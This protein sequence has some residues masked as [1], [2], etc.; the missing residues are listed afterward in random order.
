MGLNYEE[1]VRLMEE[2]G[3][4]PYRA[5]QVMDWLYR[6]GVADL[7]AMPA[8]PQNLRQALKDEGYEVGLPREKARREGAD[9]TKKFLFAMVDGETI[10][11]VYIPEGPRR[12]VCVSTQVG[13]GMGCAFCATGQGGLVRNLT[14]GEI[15]GQ[16]LAVRR[17]VGL[18]ITN[19]VAMG[20]GEPL[21]N[22]EAT[23]KAFRLMGVEHGMGIAAR[24]LTISTCGLPP[25]IL[26]LAADGRQWQLTVSLHAVRDELRDRLMPINRR[27]PLAALR[28]ACLEYFLRVG[29]RITFAYVVIPGVNDGERDAAGLVD[30]CRGMKVHLNLIPWNPV[31]GVAFRAPSAAEIER[32]R[33]RLAA[34]GLNVTVR[35]PR[36]VEFLAACGQLRAEELE[37]RR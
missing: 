12:T 30:F 15:V 18:R 33:H 2:H 27:Y 25:G 4:P 31:P 35:R 19:V 23:V 26:R 1:V 37:G 14:A 10:E 11:S 3:Q 36:G 22:Y 13:C 5:R 20:Q 8:L 24:H 6:R 28:E 29:R 16:V 21:A 34:T 9:G 7:A 32:F 17:A